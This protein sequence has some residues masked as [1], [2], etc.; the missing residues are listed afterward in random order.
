MIKQLTST[1]NIL[2]IY[3]KAVARK[4]V[5]AAKSLDLRDCMLIVD[6]VLLN[7]N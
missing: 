4:K 7:W 1:K 5:K 3:Y 6:T 2:K